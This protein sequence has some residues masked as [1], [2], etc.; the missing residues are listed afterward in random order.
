MNQAG[1]ERL[2]N[3]PARWSRHLATTR[4]WYQRNKEKKAA[5]NKTYGAEYRKL[6][7]KQP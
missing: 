3:N 1:Y 7:R 4:A 2:K 6:L 5:Y